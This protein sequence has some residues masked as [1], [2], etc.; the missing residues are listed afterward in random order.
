[1]KQLVYAELVNGVEEIAVRV[2]N[3]TRTIREM[4]GIFGRVRA[5][6]LRRARVCIDK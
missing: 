2:E 4:L 1:M 6:W 3:A 5:S